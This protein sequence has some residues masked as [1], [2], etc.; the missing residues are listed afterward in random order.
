MRPIEQEINLLHSRLCA[1]LADPKRILL[2]YALG[3]RPMNVSELCESLDLPQP[4]TSRHLRMLRERG[5][6]STQREGNMVIY[7]LADHRVIRALDT[8]RA[9]LAD[10]LAS[11]ARI[12]ETVSQQLDDGS[13]PTQG[14]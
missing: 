1:A 4:T 5:L 8:L 14:A 2:L 12:A 9:V 13:T 7:T 6:V 10:Q 11:Q 3:E